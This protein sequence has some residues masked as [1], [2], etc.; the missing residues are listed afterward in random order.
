LQAFPPRGK[1][2]KDTSR[3]KRLEVGDF[4]YNP[5]RVNVGSIALCRR[6]DEERLGQP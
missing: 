5:M 6:A 2:G 3:Y 1:P 4:V